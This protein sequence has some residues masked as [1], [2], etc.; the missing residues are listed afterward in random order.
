MRRLNF[1]NLISITAAA[2]LFVFGT[3]IP[4]FSDD[5]KGDRDKDHLKQDQQAKGHQDQQ[6]EQEQA[7]NHQDQQ[8]QQEQVR[9]QQDRNHQQEKQRELEQNREQER[10][11]GI[12][13]E[14]QHQQEQQ[15]EQEQQR[16]QNEMKTVWQEQRAQNWKTEHRTWKQRGGYNGYRIPSVNY[17]A[18][19][20]RNHGFRINRLTF[21]LFGHDT[22]FQYNGYWFSPV[23]PW[24]E[25]WSDNWYENDDVY[26][27][28]YGGG[29]YLY[30]RRH[31]RDRVAITFYLGN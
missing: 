1:M 24:P 9:N 22:R 28:Y 3:A 13:Q 26:I 14:Q 18:S 19:F 21:Q 6:R 15:R 30:N 20:G 29:Y 11:A 4:A 12:R 8:H 17:R 7:R 25:Y 16:H 2:L 5:D 27:D 23:D 10:Q 31:P